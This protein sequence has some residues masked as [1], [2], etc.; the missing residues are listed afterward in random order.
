MNTVVVTTA[1]PH[2][3]RPAH[4]ARFAHMTRAYVYMIDQASLAI[5]CRRVFD[6]RWVSD[7]RVDLVSPTGRILE[8]LTLTLEV[9]GEIPAVVAATEE[10]T[11]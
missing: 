9:D 4:T 7:D 10:R 1:Y 2:Q 6:A 3:H 8:T 11:A 5:G